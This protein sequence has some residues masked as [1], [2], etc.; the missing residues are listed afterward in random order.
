MTITILKTVLVIVILAVMILALLAMNH[1]L[2]GNFDM[3]ES[4]TD[5]FRDDVRESRQVIS[6]DSIF[7]DLVRVR[8]D[9]HSVNSK[10][11]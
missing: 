4:D 1:Y 7:G 2:S 3:S 10:K 11:R 6:D 9:P 5:R 8:V